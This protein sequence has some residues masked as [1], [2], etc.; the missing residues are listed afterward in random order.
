MRLALQSG[1]K[2]KIDVVT[3]INT[4]KAPYAM[5]CA[6]RFL[7]GKDRK[8]LNFSHVFL[9]RV[10]EPFGGRVLGICVRAQIPFSTKTIQPYAE[11]LNSLKET[12]ITAT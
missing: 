3:C 11:H 10:T 5:K 6:E 2:K 1:I 12:A 7:V 9:I 8:I 4:E